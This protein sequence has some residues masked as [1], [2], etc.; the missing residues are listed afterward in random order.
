[1][2]A[3]VALMDVFTH[4]AVHVII[5]NPTLFLERLMARNYF[6]KLMEDVDKNG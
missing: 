3:I 5:M 4:H 6:N 1:M 2:H